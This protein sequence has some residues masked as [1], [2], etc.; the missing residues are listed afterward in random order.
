MFALTLV[1][2][3]LATA[4]PVNNA[5]A[6]INAVRE[7]LQPL[8]DNGIFNLT[9]ESNEFGVRFRFGE[10]NRHSKADNVVGERIEIT[11]ARKPQKLGS[12]ITVKAIK[13][14]LYIDR[15]DRSARKRW[16]QRIQEHLESQR[17]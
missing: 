13:K 8:V 10:G 1:I 6:R 11:V 4:A 2:A 16:E 7:Y 9:E 5:D 12:P 14:G 15:R 17:E 3:T